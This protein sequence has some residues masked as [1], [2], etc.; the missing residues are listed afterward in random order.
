MEMRS[1]EEGKSIKKETEEA[2][3]EINDK[4]EFRVDGEQLEGKWKGIWKKTKTL[5]EVNVRKL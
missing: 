3:K 4:I 5:N 2:L 1:D